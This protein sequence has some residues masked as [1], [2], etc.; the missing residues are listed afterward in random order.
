MNN[1]IFPESN[2][3]PGSGGRRTTKTQ[4]VQR[5]FIALFDQLDVCYGMLTAKIERG[6]PR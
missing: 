4:R 1:A 6:F 5:D 2:G 3:I